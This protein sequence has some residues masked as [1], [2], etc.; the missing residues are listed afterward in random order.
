MRKAISS[1]PASGTTRFQDESEAQS[2]IELL[3]VTRDDYERQDIAKPKPVPMV[4]ISW[5]QARST[6]DVLKD[7]SELT[8][9]LEMMRRGYAIASKILSGKYYDDGKKKRKRRQKSQKRGI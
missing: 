4:E 8:F 3:G 9:R 2:F 5:Q 1:N 6:A 7:A